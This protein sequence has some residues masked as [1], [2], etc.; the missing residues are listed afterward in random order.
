M[1]KSLDEYAK[2]IKVNTRPNRGGGNRRGGRGGGS[3]PQQQQAQNRSF[4]RSFNN[5]INP[6][7]SGGNVQKRR[8][9]GGN[10]SLSPNKAAAAVC[11]HT[12]H[13]SLFSH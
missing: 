12:F 11:H 5:N 4:N 13:P 9:A 7:R 2:E 8:S 1:D 6:R 10:A 3:Q